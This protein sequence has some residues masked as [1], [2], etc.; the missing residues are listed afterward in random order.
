MPVHP[1]DRPLLAVQ[2]GGDI[3]IDEA[4]PFGLR[5][6]PNIF[7]AIADA[8]MWALKH[9]EAWVTTRNARNSEQVP[10][11]LLEQSLCVNGCAF[12]HKKREK[13]TENLIHR[14]RLMDA[15]RVPFNIFDKSNLDF[16]D[17]HLVCDSVCSDL[18][19]KEFGATVNH[20]EVIPLKHEER[21]WKLGLLDFD[22]PKVL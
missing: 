12:I 5:S 8:L 22:N 15:N 3:L 21:L 16:R 17:L 13:K 2:W 1:D 6:A 9:F 4:L 11:N 10:D 20:A 18:L 14:R 19:K 7:T